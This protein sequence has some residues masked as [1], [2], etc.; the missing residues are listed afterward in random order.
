MCIRDRAEALR[1]EIRRDAESLAA[2]GGKEQRERLIDT[3]YVMPHWPRPWGR[4]AGALQQLVI[5]EEF[6]VAGVTRPQLG[7]TGWV[8]QTITQ[9][10]SEDQ[11]E[12]WV[13]PT[14]AG[15]LIWCQLFSEDVY[16]RQGWRRP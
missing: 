1:G 9:H 14:L 15:E 8:M 7:I 13:R 2:L 5:D 11:I 16:K 4:D 10:G 12:R 3:G 6:A